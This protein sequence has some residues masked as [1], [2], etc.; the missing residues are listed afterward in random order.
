MDSASAPLGI[1]GNG[2]AYVT[3]TESRLRLA[4]LTSSLGAGV[5]GVSIG[6]LLA[7]RIGSLAVPILLLGALLHAWGMFDKHRIEQRTGAADPWWSRCLYWLCWGLLG[8]MSVYLLF[9]R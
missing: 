9:G 3:R 6:V 5:I 7:G 8:A 4:E 2:G 1:A